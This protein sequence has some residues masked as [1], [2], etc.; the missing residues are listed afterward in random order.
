MV[1]DPFY[2][3]STKSIK[4]SAQSLKICFTVHGFPNILDSTVLQSGFCTNFLK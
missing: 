3:E 2:D 4:D 1:N